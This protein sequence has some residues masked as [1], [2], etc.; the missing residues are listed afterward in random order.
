MILRA[1]ISFSGP[2]RRPKA[3]LAVAFEA[4]TVILASVGVAVTA[5]AAALVA[6]AILSQDEMRI[7]VLVQTLSVH[8]ANSLDIT[9]EDV[10]INDYF[11]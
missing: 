8:L 7:L 4:L 11:C 9:L 1:A 2:M 3:A 10:R 6:I 5:A